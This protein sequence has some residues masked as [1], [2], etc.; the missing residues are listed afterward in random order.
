MKGDIGGALQSGSPEVMGEIE[1]A[2]RLLIAI[3]IE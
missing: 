1:G 3:G 2:V